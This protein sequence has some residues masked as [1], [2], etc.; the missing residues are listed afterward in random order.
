MAPYKC[1]FLVFSSNKNSDDHEDIDIKL[2]GSKIMAS[3]NPFFLALRF[4]C[5]LSLKNQVSYMKES[6]LK[7]INVL[8]V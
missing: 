3:K 8:K 1:C 7:R 2:S 4:A 6:C 5:H